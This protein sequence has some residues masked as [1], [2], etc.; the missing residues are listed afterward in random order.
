MT[1][2]CS[3]V[4]PTFNAA[5][6]LD[7]CLEAVFAHPPA[8]PHELIVVDDGS[9]DDT[10]R[11]L[12]RW[13]DALRVV[14]NPENGGFAAACNAGAAACGGRYLVFLNNDTRPRRGWLDA[15]VEHA[16]AHP[17]A[18]ALGAKLLYPDET[19]QHAGVVFCQDGYPRHLYAGFPCDHPAVNRPRALQ[20]VTAACILVRRDAFERAGGF[21]ESYRNGFEDVDL[22]LR[23]GEG[24]GE[25]RYCPESVVEHLESVSEGRFAHDRDNVRRYRDRWANR[26]RRDDVEHYLADGLIRFAYESAYPHTVEIAPELAALES[27]SRARDLEALLASRSRQVGALLRETARLIARIAHLELTSVGMRRLRRG[28]EADGD[29]GHEPHG[30]GSDLTGPAASE[31]NGDP[32]EEGRRHAVLESRLLALQEAVAAGI[33]DRPGG[34][35]G[36]EPGPELRHREGVRRA[37]D[38]AGS[39]IPRGAA[40]LVVSHGDPELVAVEGARAAHF[41]QTQD[42]A[43]AGHHPASSLEAIAQLEALRELGKGEY[44]LIPSASRWWLDHYPEFHGHL[45]RH[46]RTIADEPAGVIYELSR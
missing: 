29:V 43:Y 33:C 7:R 46:Y 9:T 34:E 2:A 39:R 1:P 26:V 42:E 15:L 38:L 19:V 20:A 45:E 31:G 25:I 37:K 35:S 18:A 12:S 32:H 22:C 40:L 14:H 6:L 28:L 21:D 4:I 24:G 16:D 5:G 10:F 13:G 23:L 3:I 41:P 17:E 44:L 30:L 11:V 36:F 27:G 8:V